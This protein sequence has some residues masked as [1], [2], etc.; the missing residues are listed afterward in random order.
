[1]VPVIRDADQKNIWQLAREVIDLST[2]ARE[3]KLK[4]GEMQGASFTLSSLGA[5]G[6]MGFTPVVNTPE[7]AI[8]GISRSQIKPVWNGRAF[9]P[10]NML[11]LS[12]SYDHRAINGADAGRFLTALVQQIETIQELADDRH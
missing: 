7:V 5:I 10:A 6:G 11:P 4:P 3:G 12:L 1:M 8:L 9:E 2:R